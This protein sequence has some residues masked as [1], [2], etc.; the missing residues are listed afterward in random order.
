M[1][2][3]SVPDQMMNYLLTPEPTMVTSKPA[4]DW[5]ALINNTTDYSVDYGRWRLTWEYIGE[6]K[7]DNYNED[8]PDDMPL[9]RATLYYEEDEVEDGSYCT[10][11]PVDTD[12]DILN[13]MSSSLFGNLGLDFSNYEKINRKVMQRWTHDTNP[14]TW[15]KEG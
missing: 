8:D 14:T 7:C 4:K 6:G 5:Q 12:Q 11:A 2:I 15:N 9:L 10:F 13:K 1:T 3:P